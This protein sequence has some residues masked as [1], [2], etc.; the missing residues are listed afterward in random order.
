MARCVSIQYTIPNTV[1]AYDEIKEVLRAAPRDAPPFHQHHFARYCSLFRFPLVEPQDLNKTTEALV[2]EKLT[3]RIDDFKSYLST[4]SQCYV[5]DFKHSALFPQ[6]NTTNIHVVVWKKTYKGLNV[7]LHRDMSGRRTVQQREVNQVLKLQNED[8]LVVIITEGRP[9]G[10]RPALSLGSINYVADVQCNHEAE[11]ITEHNTDIHIGQKRK[12]I[13]EIYF[14]NCD[15]CRSAKAA[16]VS[17]GCEH[18]LCIGCLT[19]ICLVDK[20]CHVRGCTATLVNIVPK[21]MTLNISEHQRCQRCNV[22]LFEYVMDE[23]KHVICEL[24]T[25]RYKYTCDSCSET[26]D[27]TCPCC[28]STSDV[29]KRLFTNLPNDQGPNYESF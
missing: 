8:Q 21:P 27:N 14:K 15:V 13:S 5:N 26:I 6:K 23:C 18:N 28:Q 22:G 12:D 25:K 24:C 9:R 4:F 16:F 20:K 2:N 17:L 19:S 3:N 7:F 11:W 10:D 29:V 1:C